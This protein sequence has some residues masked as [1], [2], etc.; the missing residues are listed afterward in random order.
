MEALVNTVCRNSDGSARDSCSIRF[1]DLRNNNADF[2]PLG[3]DSVLSDIRYSI[4]MDRLPPFLIDGVD[5]GFL[6]EIRE[7]AF[8][9]YC[10]ERENTSRG[11]WSEADSELGTSARARRFYPDRE[12]TAKDDGQGVAIKINL[13][14]ASLSNVDIALLALSLDSAFEMP[15]FQFR[16]TAVDWTD[17]GQDARMALLHSWLFQHHNLSHI[18]KEARLERPTVPSL[19][20]DPDAVQGLREDLSGLR[21]FSAVGAKGEQSAMLEIDSRDS[22]RR[23]RVSMVQLPDVVHGKLLLRDNH[24][25]EDGIVVLF[26]VLIRRIQVLRIRLF[27]LRGCTIGHRFLALLADS[28]LTIA[29]ENLRDDTELGATRTTAS[30]F[31]ASL[32]S[33]SDIEVD[34]VES[35]DDSMKPFYS[36][37][38]HRKSLLQN[39]NFAFF[40][41]EFD[42]IDEVLLGRS[43]NGPL[44]QICDVVDLTREPLSSEEQEAVAIALRRHREK[45][46]IAA[47]GRLPQASIE[48]PRQT[49]SETEATIGVAGDHDD[50]SKAYCFPGC[51]IE[52]PDAFV[53]PTRRGC[54]CGPR[55]FAVR[56]KEQLTTE[57]LKELNAYEKIERLTVVQ[58]FQVPL[59]GAQWNTLFPSPPAPPKL[60]DF[61]LDAQETTGSPEATHRSRSSECFQ[62]TFLYVRKNFSSSSSSSVASELGGK[63]FH[64]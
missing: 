45:R 22:V 40:C 4:K 2:D 63:N 17:G 38:Q 50:K 29:R 25:N 54:H 64:W 35:T 3:Y 48:Q 46:Y 37:E 60:P 39:A 61:E 52:K 36:T 21:P 55:Y 8:K 34:A 6:H 20:K 10:Q 9:R 41:D 19:W 16:S 26:N 58:D 44:L 18:E 57:L 23:S 43:S 27:D 15:P 14:S 53:L 1:L 47:T 28:L 59:I 62:Q 31:G 33:Q 30:S 24:F 32:L 7:T 12:V 49:I 42:L 11:S 5:F 56:V 51:S 13:C